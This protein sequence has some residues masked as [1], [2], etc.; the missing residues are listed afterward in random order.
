MNVASDI[1]LFLLPL[2]MV[3]QLKLSRKEKLG[4]ALVFMSGIMYAL[5]RKNMML[6]RLTSLQQLYSDHAALW[7]FSPKSK[8]T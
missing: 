1:L 2:P 5:A 8:C 6:G 7:S 3:W 4:L